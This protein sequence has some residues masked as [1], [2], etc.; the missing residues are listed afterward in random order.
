MKAHLMYPDRD[1][2]FERPLPANADD[3][4]RDL[5]L[6]TL[7]DAMAAHNSYIRERAQMALHDLLTDPNAVLFRQ[8]VLA[9]CIKQPAVVRQ[10]YNLAVEGV[11]T[12]RKAHFFW[13]RD[14]S[15]ALL[16]K[17]LG[18]LDLLVDVLRRLRKI[19]DEQAPSFRS[20]GFARLFATLQ[21][22]LDDDYLRS[23]DYHLGELRFRRG[24]LIS[25]RL[26]RANRGTD[27]VLRKPHER[28]LFER[29]TPG[30]SPS[31]SFTIPARDEHG[32]EAVAEL[33]GRGINHAANAVAQS[34]DHILAFFAMLRAELAFYVGCLNLQE[35]LA[36]RGQPTCFPVPLAAEPRAYA[37]HGLYDAALAF[38]LD[39]H[40]IGNDVDADGKPLVMITGANRGGKSTFLRSVG[41]AQL[42]MQA[43]MFVP[44]ESFRGSVCPGI[45]T[46]FKREED[47]SMAHGKLDEELSRMSAIADQITPVS[48]LLCNESFA[49]TNE[50]EGSE[51]ARNVI[52]AML[53]AGVTVFFVTH[54][55]DLAD[56]LHSDDAL[57]A[58]FLRAERQ[59]DGRRTFRVVPGEPLPTSYGEDS[60]RRIFGSD[61]HPRWLGDVRDS[62]V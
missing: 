31:Y 26:G 8:A 41:L 47:A 17:S 57:R 21:L 43:G 24:A 4:E 16:Q 45:F 27:Y 14:T 56:S 7:L 2:D 40:V 6:A 55:F 48:M 23:V 22:E 18:I 29:L 44:A 42:M 49:A 33:R 30:G 53:D 39:G 36:E 51:I 5:E 12:K 38:H 3:L 10:L 54:L 34:A 28:T 9:D 52:R 46:H 25:A 15:D 37:V 62:S 32:M 1:V 13:F 60:Y 59:P 58:L 19:T 20:D 61:R 35:Q 50:R 11:E